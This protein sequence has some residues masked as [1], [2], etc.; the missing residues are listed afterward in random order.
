MTPLN[1]VPAFTRIDLDSLDQMVT[2]VFI[3]VDADQE[4]FVVGGH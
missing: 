3:L 1:L 4:I 2:A